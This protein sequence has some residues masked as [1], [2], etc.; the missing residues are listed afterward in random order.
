MPAV[1]QVRWA[2]PRTP[3]VRLLAAL[4]LLVR[5]CGATM[6]FGISNYE[7]ALLMLMRADISTGNSGG[8]KAPTA[9]A[10]PTPNRAHLESHVVVPT[11]DYRDDAIPVFVEI[12]DLIGR[13]WRYARF[14]S[15]SSERHPISARAHLESEGAQGLAIRDNLT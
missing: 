7:A 6:H 3:A 2:V 11:W 15:G 4:M 5:C 14:N 12:V 10:R 13:F 1:D 9:G 8:G